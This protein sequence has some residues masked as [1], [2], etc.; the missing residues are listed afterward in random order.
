MKLE[1]TEDNAE[2]CKALLDLYIEALIEEN[3]VL[4]KNKIRG[5][6]HSIK[7]SLGQPQKI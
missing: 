1:L 3:R 6:K 7:I 4:S 5:H 2:K